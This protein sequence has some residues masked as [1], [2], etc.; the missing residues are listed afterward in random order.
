[1]WDAG[2]WGLRVWLHGLGFRWAV[3]IVACPRPCVLVETA[4]RVKRMCLPIVCSWSL[5]TGPCSLS[6]TSCLLACRVAQ[7]VERPQARS[8]SSRVRAG[9]LARTCMHAWCACIL[10]MS[11]ACMRACCTF[12]VALI[13]AHMHADVVV[14][15]CGAAV[16]VATAART[17]L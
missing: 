3:V 12:M 11:R 6:Y 5:D 16:Q 17:L 15:H 4:Q 7:G 8:T 2:L 13:T 10:Y 1:M 9:L 14:A